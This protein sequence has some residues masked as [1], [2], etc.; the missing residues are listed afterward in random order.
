[1]TVPETTTIETLRDGEGLHCDTADL[2]IAAGRLG[3][4]VTSGV[5]ADA[6]DGQVGQC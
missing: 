1:M 4:L 5:S 6:S 2:E 3:L